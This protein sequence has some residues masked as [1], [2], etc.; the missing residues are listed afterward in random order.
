MHARMHARIARGR[1]GVAVC[2]MEWNGME[3]VLALQMQE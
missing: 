2:G 3:I 1:A